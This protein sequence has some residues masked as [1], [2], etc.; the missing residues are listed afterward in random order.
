MRQL[1]G[2]VVV[3]ET[4]ISALKRHFLLVDKMSLFFAQ[5]PNA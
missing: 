3:P 5:P 1:N 2:V 4:G